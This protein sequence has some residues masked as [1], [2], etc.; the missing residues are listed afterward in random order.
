[1]PSKNKF[2]HCRRGLETVTA[3]FMLLLMFA[4]L[5]GIIAA[6]SKYNLSAQQQMNIEQERAQEKIAISQVRMDNTPKISNITISNTGTI[7]VRIRA[8]YLEENGTTTFLTDP[9]TYMDT[10]IAQGSS[11]IINTTSLGLMP[12]PNAMLIATTERGTKSTRVNEIALAY[13][14]PPTNLDTSQLTVGPVM[15]RFNSLSYIETD[16]YGNPQGTWQH[17]WTVPHGVSCAWSISV[18]DVDPKNR[19]LTII[20]Y[21]GF[22]ASRVDGPQATTWYLNATQQTLMWNQTSSIIFLWSRPGGNSATKIAANQVGVNNI[23]LTLFGNYQD[24]TS[25]AQTIPFEAITIT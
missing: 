6:Y 7:E 21:T 11:K 25:F 4:I 18:T 19:S 22:T 1:M 17:Y 20:Q 3:I 12:D 10:Y 23:F 9:S 24:G 5:M 2:L 8:L 13:G 15:L 14:Q 16:Q